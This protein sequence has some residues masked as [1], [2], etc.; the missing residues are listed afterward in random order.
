VADRLTDD[1]ASLRIDRSKPPP[2]LWPRVL[3]AI[4]VVAALGAGASQAKTWADA[5][6]LA[7]EVELTE[8]VSLSPT[9][10]AV[11]LSATGY[12]VP[13]VMAR[14]G[15]KIVGRIAKVAVREGQAVKAGD[16]LFELDA[17]DLAAQ[18]ASVRARVAAA[19]AR[20]VTSRAQ[21]AEQKLVFD[22]EAKLVDSGSVPRAQ[23]DDLAARIASLEALVKAADAD[24]AAAQAEL[25]VATTGL[26]SLRITAP[27][28]G[29]A[30]TKPASV[31]DIAGPVFGAVSLVDLVDF[32][33]MLAE[34]DVPEARLSLVAPGKPCEV[35]LDALGST[36]L[37]GE[38]IE[39]G[40]RLNRAKATGLVKVK[41]LEPPASLRPEMS[42]RVSFLDKPV[43]A[44]ALAEPPKIVV[45]SGALVDRNGGRAVLV[46]ENGKVRVAPVVVGPAFG[47][48]FVLTSGPPPGTRVVKDPPPS[49]A[50]GQAAKE[51][52]ASS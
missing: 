51:K 32:G 2:R 36:R 11:S 1:L 49:L 25:G 5:H 34:V 20:A 10:A 16:L 6:V 37:R 48:G 21:V 13:Q 43:D 19:N 35:A 30:V 23:H 44:A 41:L 46:F 15:A 29:T 14:V 12:L 50:D 31:G 3:G 28:D 42:V 27:I 47:P 4:A 33:S 17:A 45:P 9:Q 18:V 24:V 26:T 52:G 8:I 40:P 38:V 7:P 22:R 39:L